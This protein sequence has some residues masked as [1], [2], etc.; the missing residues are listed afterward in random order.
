MRINP[1]A[2][3]QKYSFKKQSEKPLDVRDFYYKKLLQQGINDTFNL[4]CSVNDLDSIAGPIELR[5]LLKE[6]SAEDYMT[7]I[8]KKDKFPD[9]DAFL[10]IKKG[11]YRVNLHTHSKNSDGSMSAKDFLEMAV[12]Y[13]DKSRK[14]NKNSNKPP[15]TIALTD[16]NNIDGVKEIIS[17]IS[18]DPQKYKNLKFVTGC[19]FL[20]N[21]HNSPFEF[22][23]FEA[24]GLGFNPFDKELNG[25]MSK[26]NDISL[27]GVIKKSGGI[28]S[29]AHPNIGGNACKKEFIHYLKNIGVEGIESNYQY[30]GFRYSD[31]LVDSVNESKI[32]AK[33]F[34]LF[35]TG[36]TDSHSKN[37]FHEKA[38]KI[39]E[40]L[41]V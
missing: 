40:K 15:F 5:K 35:E 34:E 27:I 32:R 4:S 7:G 25:K 16:H 26:F 24:V 10:F 11:K 29:Y 36:G 1:F 39:I 12:K 13:A 14:H 8:F 6:F 9:E 30:L 33:E 3:Q 21:D 37:I 28:L 20:F 38:K 41:L 31:D 2:I 18:Q 19:E 17:I 23:A 22:P